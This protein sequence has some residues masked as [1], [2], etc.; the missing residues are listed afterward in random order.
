MPVDRRITAGEPAPAAIDARLAEVGLACLVVGAAFVLLPRFIFVP[1]LLVPT[2]AVY[3]VALVRR[4]SAAGRL[5]TFL[6]LLAV[7]GVAPTLLAIDASHTGSP[8]MAHDGGV[9]VTG[10][11]VQELLAGHDPYTISYADDLRG[12]FLVVDGLLTENP[13]RDHYT[14]SPGTFLVQVPFMAPVLALGFSPD[15]RWL[16]LVVF[17]A[18]G[19]GLARWSL[20][21]RG[22]LLVPLLLLCNPLF[23]PFL[24]A[25]ETD[26]LLLAGLVGLAWALAAERPVPGA[27]ALGLAISTKLLLGPFA[28]VFLV[29][30][31]ARSRHGRLDRPTAV[32][33]AV[34]LVLPAV[35]TALPF[36]LWH[37]GAMVQDVL[38]FHA[39]LAPPRYP[40][41]GAGF[42]A[43]L[44][45]LDVV[46]D[47][48]AAAPAWSTL[49][50][51]VAAL[52]GAGARVWRRTRVADLFGAGAAASLAAVYFSR[53]FTVTYWWLPLTL[54]SLAVVARP[55]R[56]PSYA[57]PEL[58]GLPAADLA[59]VPATV[60]LALPERTSR[61]AR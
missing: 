36:L 14:Y 16:Y 2:L 50:P 24:W 40:I 58:D 32:R 29:W 54:L 48:L 20:R 49:L 15:A 8:T 30:L 19:V 38:L 10:R 3:L 26:V 44:F 17:A 60:G 55:G 56:R 25:G 4:W 22:D 12:G 57:S 61:Q 45:D 46:H 53:A 21:E 42:P 33:A 35:V 23:L 5:V 43:L 41:G 34:A 31:A 52:A 59:T 28:L 51:T 1:S 18:L 39:G 11:A 13:I 6:V 27:L 7:V 37:P 9:I 47:R